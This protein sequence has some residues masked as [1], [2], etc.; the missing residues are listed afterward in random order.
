MKDF[1]QAMIYGCAIWGGLDLVSL[2]LYDEPN[3]FGKLFVA[4]L[5]FGF[6]CLVAILHTLKKR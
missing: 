4:S 3:R 5:I 6:I 1:G 2:L